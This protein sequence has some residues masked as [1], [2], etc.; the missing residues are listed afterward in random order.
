[1][2]RKGKRTKGMEKAHPFHGMS[3]VNPNAAGVDT[4]ACS[5]QA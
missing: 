3:R 5:V 2:S 4:S 1:M